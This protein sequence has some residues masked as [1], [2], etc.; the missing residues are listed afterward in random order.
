MRWCVVH[1]PPKGQGHVLFAKGKEGVLNI[2]KTVLQ[3]PLGVL[4]VVPDPKDREKLL[5]VFQLVLDM[6]E[7]G[8]PSA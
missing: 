3:E 5:D 8:A 1:Y 4:A 2:V 6:R 7:K